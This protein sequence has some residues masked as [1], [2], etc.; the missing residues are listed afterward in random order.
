M[1]VPGAGGAV[2]VTIALAPSRYFLTDVA[3]A[4]TLNGTPIYRGSFLSGFEVTVPLMPGPHGLALVIMNG[5]INRTRNYSFV[6]APGQALRVQLAYSR[7]WGNFTRGL[8]LLR[9]AAT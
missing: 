6:V 5:L 2:P 4:A 7:L 3:L 1:A 9:S 8:K